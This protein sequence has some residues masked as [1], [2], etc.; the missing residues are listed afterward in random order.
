[1]N[2]LGS[3]LLMLAMQA[4]PLQGIVVKKGTNEPLSKATVELRRDQD[5]AAV[6]NKLTTED[7]GR[8]LFANVAPGR[9]RLTVTR[10]GYVRPPLAI[11]VAAGQPGAEI[12]LPMAQA[13]TISGRVYDANGQSLG[14]VEVLAM[15]ASYPEGLR[16]L[17]PL[18]S[19]ITNDLGEYRLF[20]LAAGR[21]YISA[22]HPKAQ[23]MFRRTSLLYAISMSISGINS[24]AK[25]DAA[26]G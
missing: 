3:A 15:R 23:G 26:L 4:L 20:G 2:L 16:I 19:A 22:V 6:L 11:T 25:S 14:N 10:R 12:Q 8:F 21:Y 13:G 7:D 1:M 9:Y 18:Q 5:N 24:A 17:T